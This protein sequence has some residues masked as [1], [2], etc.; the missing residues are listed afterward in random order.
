ML[1]SDEFLCIAAETGYR[2][3]VA[4]EKVTSQSAASKVFAVTWDPCDLY[5]C[6]IFSQDGY[7]K[8]VDF[9]NNMSVVLY[10]VLFRR[11]SSVSSNV[12]PA[13]RVNTHF[14][15]ALFLSNRPGEILFVLGVSNILYFSALPGSPSRLTRTGQVHNNGFVSGTP[16]LE[17][18]AHTSRITSMCTSV[19]GNILAT[20]DES[21]N[22]KIMILQQ[23]ENEKSL[24]KYNSNYYSLNDKLIHN[25]YQAHNDTI[26]TIK[27]LPCENS[28]VCNKSKMHEEVNDDVNV[29]DSN[30]IVFDIYRQWYLV[31]GSA[32]R[33]LRVWS[34][35]WTAPQLNRKDESDISVQQIMI[36]DTLSANILD[37]NVHSL[38]S[39]DPF[40]YMKS[41]GLDRH[42]KITHPTMLISGS[43]DVG[44]VY[45]WGLS[46][47]DLI[48]NEKDVSKNNM[49]S[50]YDTSN[51]ANL[52]ITD[53]GTN[54]LSMIHSSEFPIISTNFL[55]ARN[56][57][58]DSQKEYSRYLDKISQDYQNTSPSRKSTHKMNE[59]ENGEEFKNRDKINKLYDEFLSTQSL[60]VITVDTNSTAHSH[61]AYDLTNLSKSASPNSTKSSSSPSEG[62]Q[63]ANNKE[64]IFSLLGHASYPTF[65]VSS[66]FQSS[67]L[68][69]SMSHDVC[70][71]DGI[72]KDNSQSF[73]VFLLNGEIKYY[74]VTDLLES[75]KHK[76]ISK[77]TKSSSSPN[78]TSHN[79]DDISMNLDNHKSTSSNNQNSTSAQ[80]Q[81]ALNNYDLS[82]Q[83]RKTSINEDSASPLQASKSIVMHLDDEGD[84][85]PRPPLATFHQSNN[86]NIPLSNEKPT[87]T[88]TMKSTLFTKS[89]GNDQRNTSPTNKNV[90]KPASDKCNTVYPSSMKGDDNNSSIK[91]I[92]KSVT[93]SNKSAL[94]SLQYSP[95]RN[96]TTTT[97]TKNSTKKKSNVDES[98]EPTVDEEIKR[99]RDKIRHVPKSEYSEPALNS[100]LV[101]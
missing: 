52:S 53:S 5:K 78:N 50:Q 77:D 55:F 99:H 79:V 73:I 8:L 2:L 47:V 58:Y 37:I 46:G 29:N 72:V 23:S 95:S 71:Y 96:T 92:K 75:S 7:I 81:T 39:Y 6:Y 26:F 98:S 3:C 13:K 24:Y 88:N 61:I 12:D 94:E 93:I 83:Y 1:D 32:D 67:L 45:I 89:S 30:M 20:G 10:E 87:S 14:D 51:Y 25:D 80:K 97:A 31:S 63:Y 28:G 56:G 4:D 18:Y 43:T 68:L 49:M 100:T 17:V 64:I 59:T 66:F 33:C 74:P 90:T 34:I 70:K 41:K 42:T 19:S 16:V 65:I 76:Y 91:N 9:G 57:S 22:I 40:A 27:W 84:I 11:F 85:L 54:L 69:D 62:D 44:T 38:F 36:F 15:K 48:Q 82:P 101:K 21:G 86:S 60:L 35:K